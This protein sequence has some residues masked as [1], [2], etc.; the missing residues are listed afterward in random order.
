MNKICML[1]EAQIN[2]LGAF[3]NISKESGC[4]NLIPCVTQPT[5]SSFAKSLSL[6][7]MKS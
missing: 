4:V 6:L 5:S 7:E 3:A 2:E 1:I